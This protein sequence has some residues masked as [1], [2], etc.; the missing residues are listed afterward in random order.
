M[1]IVGML[2]GAATIAA[3]ATEEPGL[4][5]ITVTAKRHSGLTVERLPPQSAVEITAPLPTDMPEAEF[6]QH[7]A[8]IGTFRRGH[9]AR[10]VVAGLA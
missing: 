9:S 2:L 10:H 1:L 5:T 3:A 6:D 8:P 7:M 4:E